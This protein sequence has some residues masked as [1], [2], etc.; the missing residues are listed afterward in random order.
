MAFTTRSPERTVVLSVQ[1]DTP[2]PSTYEVGSSGREGD[3]RGLRP[4]PF[5]TTE[6]I[7]VSF[8]GSPGAYDVSQH[9]GRRTQRTYGMR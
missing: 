3:R 6:V 9:A 7:N 4:V 5:Q 2:G 1:S 8:G